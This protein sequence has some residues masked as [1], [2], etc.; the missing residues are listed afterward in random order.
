MEKTF[1]IY[2]VS[3]GT[4]ETINAISR[5]VC[6]R[7]NNIKEIEHY[8]GLVRSPKQL[9]RVIKD[10][11]LIPGPVLFSIIDQ[12]LSSELQKI[13]KFLEVPC[14]SVLDSFINTLGN[15][16]NVEIKGQAGIQHKLS[17]EYFNRIDALNFAITHDDGQNQDNLK[18][19]DIVLVGVSR[20]SKTPTCMY[21]ANRGIKVAN[22]PFIRNN[23]AST[24]SFETLK[25]PL[26]IG[27][28]VSSD[29]LRQI[30]K[31]R[32]LSLHEETETDYVDLDMLKLETSEARRFFLRN[33]WPIIDAS[34]RSIEETS[35]TILNIYQD[36]KRKKKNDFVNS[37]Y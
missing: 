4:G 14:I 15:Y 19:A 11:K 12:D 9:E 18:N 32:L 21:L 3:D 26:I 25:G 33:H 37:E 24:K 8:Y 30:R 22:V 1:H 35:T 6:A 5:A 16:L 36:W 17:Q 27:L 7:F 29:R 10:I 20:T 2:L 13:C 34:R 31:N 23:S 28:T